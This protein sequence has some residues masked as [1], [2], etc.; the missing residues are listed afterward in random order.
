MR[1]HQVLL[2]GSTLLFSWLGMQL[3]H[4]LGHICGAILTGGEVKSV[5]LNPLTFSRTDLGRNPQP[6]VVVWAGPLGGSIV[7]LALWAIAEFLRLTGAFVVRFWAGFCLIANGAYIGFGSF[8]HL[9]DCGEMLNH[10]SSAWQLWLFGMLT[11]PLGLRLWHGQ[12]GFFGFGTAQGRVSA[13]VAYGTLI[14]AS[15]LMLLGFRVGG[16]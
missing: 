15:L 6:L 10:G 3:I 12:G 4:E 11:I 1:L 5:T 16:G 9:G 14:A 8:Q 2:I 7:P 13:A